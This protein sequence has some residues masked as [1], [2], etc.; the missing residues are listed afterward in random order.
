MNNHST[1]PEQAARERAVERYITAFECGDFDTMEPI[2]QQAVFDP[3]LDLMITEVHD[4]FLVEDNI[5]LH[6]KEQERVR[7]LVF[8]HLVSGIRDTDEDIAVPP[9]TIDYVVVK[10]QQDTKVHA[11]Y[12]QEAE[13]IYAHLPQRQIPLPEKLNVKAVYHMFEQLGVSVSAH[14]QKI[15]REKAVLL[16]MGHEQGLAQMAA[17]R[18]QRRHYEKCSQIPTMQEEN[19]ENEEEQS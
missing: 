9:L 11:L 4:Y 16:S 14:F 15:F 1:S 18:H 13:Q 19:L 7:T 2:L 10:L 5:E 3:I 12:K 8:D 6:A 17:T